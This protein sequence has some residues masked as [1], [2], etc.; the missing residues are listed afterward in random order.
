M[1]T[2]IAHSNQQPQM[3]KRNLPDQ[4]L[5][6]PILL[7]VVTALMVV[8][9]QQIPAGVTPVAAMEPEA[10]ALMVVVTQQIALGVILVEVMGPGMVIQ[11]VAE[12]EVTPLEVAIATPIIL[13]VIQQVKCHVQESVS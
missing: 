1:K 4:I 8:V 6:R 12:I 9:T 11:I 2:L 10:T 3:M 13:E 7:L 5:T